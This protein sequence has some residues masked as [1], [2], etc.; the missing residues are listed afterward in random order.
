MKNI[1]RRKF[2]Q[3]AAALSLPCSAAAQEKTILETVRAA[4]KLQGVEVIDVHAHI[5]EAPPGAI[6]PQGPDELLEEMDRCGVKQAVF[7]HLGAIEASEP[8]DLLNGIEA[9]VQVVRKHSSRFRSYLVFHPHLFEVSR[10]QMSRLLEPASPFIGFKLH[11]AFHQYPANGPRYKAVF[12]FA[13]SHRLP[14]LFHVAGTGRDW[15][16]S[17][18]A[19]ADEYKQIS[20]ILA[21][22]GPGEDA[23]PELMKGRANLFTDTCLSTGRH[24]LIERLAAKIGAEKLLFATDATFDSVASHFAKIAFT[25]LPDSEKKLILGGN[26]R[27]LFG[28]RLPDG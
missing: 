28:W 18:G 3:T 19:I 22:M 13:H 10:A 11:G 20:L 7:S 5:S 17:V 4:E 12:E 21:H 2:I 16:E 27:R 14:V 25:D 23:L 6:W 15:S 1:N 8:E 26:A 24:R 9:S